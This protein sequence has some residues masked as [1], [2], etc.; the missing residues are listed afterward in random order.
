[1]SRSEAALAESC[2]CQAALGAVGGVGR[3]RPVDIDV[4]YAPAAGLHGAARNARAPVA[5]A[6]SSNG[7][8]RMKERQEKA[9]CGK[10]AKGCAAFW[11]SV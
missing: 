4:K 2:R 6:S 11:P 8:L 1:M 10:T 9:K 3:D 7:P 5:T